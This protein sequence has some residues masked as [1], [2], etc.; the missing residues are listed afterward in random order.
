MG[1]DTQDINLQWNDVDGYARALEN[2]VKAPNEFYA[3]LARGAD[4]AAQMYG[5]S[6]YAMT[7]GGNEVSGYHT[8]P[9][10]IVGQLVGVRHSHLDNAGYSIDQKAIKKHMDPEAIADEI[11]K[12][13]NSRGVFNSLV[14]CLF[15]RGVYTEENIID[16]LGAVGIVKTEDDLHELGG[17][18]FEEKY[19]FKVQEG[20]DLS[21]FRIPKRFYETVSAAGLVTAERVEE[22]L[23]IYRKKRGW[24]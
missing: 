12:E 21:R 18:I 2:I 14:C 23:M 3:A 5:G 8:G 11:I 9:A 4:F 16:S 19:R 1:K 15:A 24:S 20:F 22:I 7:L 10:S 6:E 17:R 13:D